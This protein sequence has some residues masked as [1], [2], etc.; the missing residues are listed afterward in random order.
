MDI[1]NISIC[2][3]AHKRKYLFNEIIQHFSKFQETRLLRFVFFPKIAEEWLCAL[4]KIPW[5]RHCGEK[6]C[7]C[8]LA[9]IFWNFVI[10]LFTNRQSITFT[11][12]EMFGKEK[13]ENTNYILDF[14]GQWNIEALNKKPTKMYINMFPQGIRFYIM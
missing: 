8:F 6:E 4:G 9:V 3:D 11:L 2:M 1:Q 7:F 5:S 14:Y 12:Q 13:C 10:C